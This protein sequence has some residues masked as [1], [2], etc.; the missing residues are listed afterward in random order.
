MGIFPTC[1]F[2]F[3]QVVVSTTR[4]KRSFSLLLSLNLYCNSNKKLGKYIKGLILAGLEP[5]IP[6]FVVRCLVHWATRPHIVLEYKCFVWFLSNDKSLLSPRMN[7]LEHDVHSLALSHYCTTRP[8]W[9]APFG[10][11]PDTQLF[12]PPGH[13]GFHREAHAHTALSADATSAWS[14]TPSE[15]N[16]KSVQ[17]TSSPV[18]EL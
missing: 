9:A 18:A 14:A 10:A 13:H 15:S 5:A 7:R 4:Y 1:F 6:W 2:D 8:V 12:K 16:S 11:W 3:F 17:Q